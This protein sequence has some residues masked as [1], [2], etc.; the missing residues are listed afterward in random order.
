MGYCLFNAQVFQ[1]LLLDKRTTPHF[2]FTHNPPQ[3]EL[4]RNKYSDMK[5]DIL[6]FV[7]YSNGEY[8][9][10]ADWNNLHKDPQAWFYIK[11]ICTASYRYADH[12]EYHIIDKAASKASFD[13]GN[14]EVLKFYTHGTSA[15]FY[16][17]IELKDCRSG[18]LHKHDLHSWQD[19]I[20]D[21]LAVLKDINNCNSYEVY[22]L[23]R[24][25]KA[26][27]VEIEQLKNSLN[28][29]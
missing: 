10:D 5:G 19:A 13:I 7:V 20:K 24:E 17:T 6:Y 11:R 12:Y 21:M 3:Q 18:H 29:K 22:T 2:L 15:N 14:F 8:T 25:N 4:I 27:R 26:L 16:M 9:S 23:Q 1:N 28:I